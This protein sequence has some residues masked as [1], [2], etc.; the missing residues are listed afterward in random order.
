[1]TLSLSDA[2]VAKVLTYDKLIPAMERALIQFSAGKVIQPGRNVLTIEEG[3]RFLGV[4]P[5][6]AEE[7]IGAKLICFFPKNTGLDRRRQE[8]AH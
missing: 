1:M 4:M 5:V 3:K 2:D 6:A 7:G 8:N